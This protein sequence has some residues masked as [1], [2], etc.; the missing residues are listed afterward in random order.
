MSAIFI[1]QQH[2]KTTKMRENGEHKRMEDRQ[3]KTQPPQQKKIYPQART[4]CTER[5]SPNES[6]RGVAAGELLL[7]W[8]GAE[9]CVTLKNQLDVP[10]KSWKNLNQGG[11]TFWQVFEKLCENK[12]IGVGR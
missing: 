4:T 3:C 1:G 8:D 10:L 5:Y 6:F 2:K 11:G 12:K 9:M 7:E